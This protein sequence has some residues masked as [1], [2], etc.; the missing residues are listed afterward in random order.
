VRVRSSICS[1]ACPWTRLSRRVLIW[2]PLTGRRPGAGAADH[3]VGGLLG[4]ACGR[5]QGIPEAGHVEL[6]GGIDSGRRGAAAELI[7]APAAPRDPDHRHIHDPAFHRPTRVE[8]VS[9]FARLPLAPRIT[10]RVH[11]VRRHFHVYERLRKFDCLF[12]T[13]PA[14]RGPVVGGR[15]DGDRLIIDAGHTNVVSTFVGK[16]SA[17]ADVGH[18]GKAGASV[19]I[20]AANMIE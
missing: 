18:R 12:A 11:T 1:R 19:R 7:Q 14:R 6:A 16:P 13:V 9:S 5:L 8:R 2:R 3:R 17:Y 15:R 20:P 4:P 10:K